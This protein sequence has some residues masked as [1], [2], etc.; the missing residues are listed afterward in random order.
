MLPAAHPFFFI[1]VAIVHD[2]SKA[3]IYCERLPLQTALVG[4][5]VPV[6]S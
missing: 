6:A 1:V 2:F 3:E 4:I 5:S